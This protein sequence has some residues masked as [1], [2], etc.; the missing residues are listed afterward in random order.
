[1]T[2]ERKS[3]GF[4]CKH[5]NYATAAD[6]SLNDLLFIKEVEH[7]SD[8]TTQP[9]TRMI[10]NF[11]RHFYVTKEPFRNH[12]E[13][14]ESEPLLRLRRFPTTQIEMP[15]RVSRALGRGRPQD[16]RMNRIC[17]SPYVYG[18]DVTTPVLAKEHYM[19]TWPQNVSI[20]TLAAIDS[21][22][23]METEE[24]I[25]L[26]VTYKSKARLI[27][28]EGF[29]K[30]IVD[31][32][33]ALH[34]MARE[35]IGDVLESRNIQLEIEL[36]ANAGDCAAR[37]IATAHE[38]KPDFLAAWN[39]DYDVPK[40]I[41]ALVRYGYDPNQ[42]FPDPSVP[43]HF[44]RPTHEGSIPSGFRNLKDVKDPIAF[45]RQFGYFQGKKN[46]VTA[47]GDV[48]PLH[49]A[50]QWHQLDQPASWYLIDPMCVYLR[51]RVAKGKE[52][53]YSLDAILE[54]HGV[55][56]KLKFEA[57]DHLTKGAWHV[58]MQ[59]NYR[60]EYCIYNL[61][62]S[63][64]IE[65][66]DEVTTDLRQQISSLCG[67]SEYHRF[68][69]QPRRLAD[70]FHFFA[71]QR[72]R[73]VGSTSD[74]MEMEIDSHVISMEGWIVTLPSWALSPD[75]GVACVEEMPEF[76]SLLFA[77]VADLD[78]EGTY[79]NEEVLMNISRSTT[80]MELVDIEDCTEATRRAIG[81]NLTSGPTNAV[82]ITTALYKAPE[83]S[84]LLTLY[85]SAA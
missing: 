36:V 64:A 9:R 40:M 33:P 22:T 73:V 37:A 83:L 38:W 71:L 47:G 55:K 68:P 58:F 30:G 16:R 7:F 26:S 27:V 14:K 19:R 69:S 78:V 52:Q 15:D 1:M 85:R 35:Y 17:R 18:T 28:V 77:H 53:S 63:I 34:A 56:R 23:D 80:K 29:L 54:K 25:M 72:D 32:I 39:M 45:L 75:E 74:Q 41:E 13:K 3:V 6:G 51:M 57:A 82:E 50:E 31:P 48:T 84:D 67:F 46:K 79:P 81:V 4:E 66:L 24:I 10:R 59:K 5:V 21:E 60:L 49:P 8:G 43:Q 11:Q 12:Q 20:N 76:S 44:R 42:L 62:D 2:T 70:D 61:Y 65:M